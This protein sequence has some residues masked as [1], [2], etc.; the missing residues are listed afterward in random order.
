[1]RWGGVLCLVGLALPA[2]QPQP[3]AVFRSTTKLIQVSV[4]AQDKKGTPV[5]DLRSEDFKIFDNG[6]PQEIR[7]FIA[8]KPEPSLPDLLPPNTF[9]NVIA[10][11]QGASGFGGRSGYS[12]ILFDNLVTGFGLPGYDGTGMGRLRVLKTLRSIPEGEK[13]ALYAIGREL[14]I[15][16]EFTT[17]RE[18]LERRLQTWTPHVDAADTNNCAPEAPPP[19]PAGVPLT[20][21]SGR[22]VPVIPGMEAGNARAASECARIDLELRLKAFDEQLKAVAEHLAGVPGR[23][24]LIWLANRFP[25]IG[26]PA[27]QR[28]MNAGVSIYPVDEAGVC[29]GCPPRPRQEMRALAEMTGGLP[30][31]GRNDLDIAVREA[32]DDG[33]VSYTLGFYQPGD[34]KVAAI[35][36]LTVKVSRPSVTLRYRTSYSV[37]PPQPPSANPVA[38][39]VQAMNRPMDATTIP[40]TASAT[41][42]QDRLNL[43]ATIDLAGLDLSLN[44]GLWTGKLEIVARFLAS[45]GTQAGDVSSDTAALNLSQPSYDLV[46]TDGFV[47]RKELNVPSNAVELKLLVANLATGKIGTLTIPLAGL[48]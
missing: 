15:V 23:K 37:E 32:M 16:R 1:M 6:A 44:Q 41:R 31:F 19:P 48:R 25:I 14:Q 27:V 33:R 7:L 9:T 17:D 47:Y 18:S 36:Q 24:N 26:G 20:L 21:S 34:D 13:M 3:G 22:G 38:D 8:E 45:N 10:G 30:F 4:I 40:I 39:L 43:A 11:G 29:R 35:H 2:Q 28:L 5:P 12:V 42:T 46:L